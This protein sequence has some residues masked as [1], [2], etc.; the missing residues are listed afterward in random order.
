MYILQRKNNCV[1]HK[2]YKLDKLSL[3]LKLKSFSKLNI[4]KTSLILSNLYY[5]FLMS[6]LK[7]IKSLYIKQLNVLYLNV[8]YNKNYLNSN[9]ILYKNINISYGTSTKMKRLITIYDSFYKLLL[10]KYT[11]I[12]LIKFVYTKCKK[13]VSLPS[14]SSLWTVLKSPFKYKKALVQYVK[15]TRLKKIRIPSWVNISFLNLFCLHTIKVKID[16]LKLHRM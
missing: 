15:I 11:Y 10:Y 14:K 1:L 5:S 7:I 4:L 16:F 13:W 2:L 8:Q 6:I 12:D 3:N 9:F